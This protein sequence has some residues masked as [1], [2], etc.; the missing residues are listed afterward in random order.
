[1]H[2][3]SF[4][5]A[6]PHCVLFKGAF[7][8]ARGLDAGARLADRLTGHGDVRT[9]AIVLRIAEEEKAV[10]AMKIFWS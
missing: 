2:V 8:E 5:V 9:A 3:S 7:Q 6:T 1:M 10:R 4:Y